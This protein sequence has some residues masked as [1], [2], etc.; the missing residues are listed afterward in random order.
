MDNRFAT[1][2]VIGSVLSLLSVIYL[3]AA[4]GTVSWYHYFTSSAQANTSYATA[5]DFTSETEKTDEKAYTDALFHFNGSLGLWQRCITVSQDHVSQQPSALTDSP[6]LSSCIF[7]SL[8]DQFL[9]K[10]QEPGNH[11]SE[12]DVVRTYLWRCQFLLPLVALGLIFFGAIVGLAGCVCHSLYPAVGTGILHL[13]A[14]VCTLGSVLC[15]S[16]GIYMLQERLPPPTGIRG[17]YG[18]SFCLACVS[19]PLQV[20]AGALFLWASCASRREYSLMKAYR[21]A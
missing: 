10:Y 16:S 15:F 8:S 11:N 20:M 7:L 1:A 2:L 21:V 12:I 19:S 9:E 13:L 4:V 3:C 14:G 18:W 6:T 17:D 5:E